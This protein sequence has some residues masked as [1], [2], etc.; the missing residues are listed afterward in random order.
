MN[1]NPSTRPITRADFGDELNDR[2]P[3]LQEM[4]VEIANRLRE[5]QPGEDRESLLRKALWQAKMWWM[6]RA[7]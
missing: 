2:E 6:D 4:A 1:D 5:E 3:E 7:G